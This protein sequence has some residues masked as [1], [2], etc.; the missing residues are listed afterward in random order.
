[1]NMRIALAF[2]GAALLAACGGGGGGSRQTVDFSPWEQVAVHYSYPYPGQIGVS[3][4]TPMVLAF[5]EPVAELT[6]DQFTLKGPNGAVELT[7]RQ[8]N[9]N[10]GVMLTPAEPLLVNS[11][12]ALT[13]N[14]VGEEGDKALLP[15]GQLAFSTRPAMDGAKEDRIGAAAFRME[16]LIPDGEKMP[17]VDFS[18][19]QIMLSQ[20][21]D[22]TTVKYGDTVRLSQGGKLVPATVLASGRF[23]TVD[24]TDSE[25]ADGNTVDALKAGEPVSLEVTNGVYSLF[26]EPLTAINRTFTPLDTQ[27]RSVMVQEAAQAADPSVGCRS[28][29][30]IKSPL[31]D[32]AINCVPMA[33]NLLGDG[34]TVSML[35]GDVF[36]EL[37]FTPNFPE[38]TPLRI[39]RGSLLHGEPLDVLIGGQIPAGFDSGAVTSTILSDANGYMMDNPYSTDINAPKFLVLTM[40]VAFDTADPRANG[41][42]TQDL[43]QVEMVGIARVEGDRL[44]ADAI[45]VVEPRVMGLENAFGM[46]SFHMASYADQTVEREP[47]VDMDGPVLNSW[48][49]GEHGDKHRPGDP[50]ILTF[51]HPLDP[52]SVEAGVSVQLSGESGTLPFDFVVDGASVVLRPETPLEYGVPYKVSFT[53]AVT[54]IAGNPAQPRTLDFQLPDYIVTD[55]EGEPIPEQSPLVLTT[56]PGFPCITIDRNLAANDAGRCDGGKEDDDHLPV[57]PLAAN[58][59]IIVTFSQVMDPDSINDTTFL[60]ET[61]DDTG[62]A[63]GVVEGKRDLQGRK[64]T[65][66]PDQPW[67]DGVLYRYTLVSQNT[68]AVCGSTALCDSRGLPLQTQLLVANPGDFPAPADGGPSLELFFRG[69][70]E[71]ELTLQQMRNLPTS[72]VNANFQ[73]DQSQGDIKEPVPSE[74]EEARRNSTRIIPN[75]D[76]A[77]SGSVSDANI[78]CEVGETCPDKQHIYVTGNLDTE[79]AG[80]RT[81]AEVNEQYPDDENIP[82]QVRQN[83]GVLVYINPTQVVTTSTV[84]Y[85]EVSGIQSVIASAPPADSGPQLMRMRYGCRAD[86][87]NCGAP[88]HGRVKGWIVEGEEG[89]RFLSKLDLYMDAPKLEPKVSLGIF[90]SITLN[91]GLHSYPLSLELAGDVIFLDDGRIQIEQR[92]LYPLNLDVDVDGSII[93]IISIEGATH[94]V[95]PEGASFLNYLSE[96]IK[97]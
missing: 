13:I 80:Y 9:G 44:V 39:P 17:F 37:A 93:G 8:I 94:V 65:F 97:Q 41:A 15:G 30:A 38:V 51:D 22:P 73:W 95:I 11:Q 5:S 16:R 84:F 36:A 67:E 35:S 82:D 72:D 91:H 2:C 4:K 45:G 74:N 26:G 47:E 70:P 25:D 29:A 50:V 40:D 62:N 59:S 46:L 31:N 20:P 64:L 28:D 78:G 81:A 83:G 23:L 96:P 87:G 92:N 55:A 54:D 56:Y 1:M 14:G 27:P 57:Q 85:S 88:D 19:V 7:L 89:L 10:K 68:G 75:P 63:T 58:R 33:S 61:V 48:T 49:P 77:G 90:G 86:E 53:D 6:A 76:G 24:P 18:T 66:K 12:Y 69:A 43:L 71:T 34:T 21:I 52:K 79:I 42:F 3:P 60:V 32:E